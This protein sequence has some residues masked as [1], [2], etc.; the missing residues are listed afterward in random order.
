VRVLGRPVHKGWTVW[1]DGYYGRPPRRR[2]ASTC[3]ATPPTWTRAG[4]IRPATA[5]DAE[6][7]EDIPDLLACRYGTSLCR[8]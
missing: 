8:R 4:L 2:V 5:V 6:R 7:P 3:S 1:R